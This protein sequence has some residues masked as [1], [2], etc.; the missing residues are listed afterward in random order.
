[1]ANI[2]FTDYKS[3]VVKTQAIYVPGAAGGV[4]TITVPSAADKQTRIVSMYLT[5]SAAMS[6]TFHSSPN[7]TTSVAATTITGFLYLPANGSIQLQ[8]TPLYT[9]LWLA[10]EAGGALRVTQSAAGVL[11]GFM[12]Y[13]EV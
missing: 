2:T 5:N 9:G 1:M 10:L 4:T 6:I 3:T 11:G 8:P 13:H 12:V 7:F